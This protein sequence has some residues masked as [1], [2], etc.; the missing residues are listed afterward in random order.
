MVGWRRHLGDVLKE[1]NDNMP[2]GSEITIF[3]EQYDARSLLRVGLTQPPEP[4]RQQSGKVMKHPRRSVLA[5]PI[6]LP[7]SVFIDL[8]GDSC[9]LG[10]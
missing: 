4:R 8:C 7:T 9:P 6:L 5:E 10:L 1:L 2:P 3:S